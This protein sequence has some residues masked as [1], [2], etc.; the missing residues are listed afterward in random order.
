MIEM[1]VLWREPMSTEVWQSESH[2]ENNDQ[3][4]GDYCDPDLA[5]CPHTAILVTIM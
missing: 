4:N 1:Q 2:C 5:C 3:K